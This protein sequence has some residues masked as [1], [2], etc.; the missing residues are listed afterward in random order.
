MVL[1]ATGAVDHGA[2]VAAAE[3]SLGGVKAG[4]APAPWEKPY[5]CGAELIYRNDEMGPTAY[6]SVGWESVPARSGDA[7]AFM[8]MQHIIGS[9]KK[10][11]GLVPGNISGN[12]TINQVANKMNV[13]CAD[14]FEAFNCFYKDTGIFGFYA[15]CDEVAVEHCIGELQFG[16]N[17]LSFSVTDEEVARGKRELKNALF[18]DSSATAACTEIGTQMLA[19]GRHVPAAEMLLRIDA[20]DAEEVK[21]VAWQYLNDA[22]VAA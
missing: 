22:E 16:I 20:V 19:Y 6:V 17:L 4:A 18:G 12:R 9:Y 14:E 21:R 3:A 15:A 8:V 1:V 11:A 7:V 2:V 10:N 13:G 5:F